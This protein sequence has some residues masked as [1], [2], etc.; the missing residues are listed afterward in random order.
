MLIYPKDSLFY[1]WYKDEEPIPGANGQY[2]V[3]DTDTNAQNGCYKV[4][5]TPQTPGACGSFTDTCCVNNPTSH[6]KTLILPNPNDGQFRLMIPEG[7]VNV[8]ILDVNG[9]VVMARKVDGDE[10][11]EMN[12][13]LANGLYFVKTF[14]TDGSFNTEKLVINR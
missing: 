9:Q 1:Q 2:Y 11:L 14:R 13:G 7:T 5:V 3:L 6:A 12:T 8:Q 10:M 4:L